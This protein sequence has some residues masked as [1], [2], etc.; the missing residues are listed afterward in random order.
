MYSTVLTAAA[1]FV[2]CLLLTPLARDAFLRWGIVDRPDGVR[3]L[4]VRPVPRAGGIPIAVSYALAYILLLLSPLKGGDYLGQFL[5]LVWALMPAAVLVFATG[6]L[7]DIWGLRPCEKLGGQLAAA[8]LACWGG[9]KIANVAGYAISGWLSLPL[10]VIW[11]AACTNAFNLID[12]V[13]GLAAGVGLVATL[14]IFLAALL[15]HNLALALATFP[16]AGCLLGF[17]R[18]NF[19]PASVFLGDSGSLLVG[20]L[21]GCYGV[22]WSQKSVTILGMTAPLMALALPLLDT[23]LAV[24]RRFLRGQ[25]IFGADRGHLHHRLLDRGLTPRRVVLLLYA[26]CG[27][28]AMP[29]LLQSTLYA[30]YTGWVLLLFLVAAVAGIQKLEYEEFEAARRLLF[31]GELRKLLNGQIALLDLERTISRTGTIEGCWSAIQ[32]GCREFGFARAELH[33]D[34]RIYGRPRP[35]TGA[36]SSWHVYVPLTDRDYVLLSRGAASA[37]RPGVVSPLAD[38]LRNRLPD[39]LAAL[40]GTADVLTGITSETQ[41]LLRLAQA[42]ESYNDSYEGEPVAHRAGP[43]RS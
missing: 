28:G 41:S 39:K 20:F 2:F 4:H 6:L 22:I 35:G 33:F 14:T 29:S 7:D 36:N 19:N 32:D 21:L 30:R 24:L 31:G 27:L 42:I 25:P 13:D 43:A 15:H 40:S 3:K 34:G 37:V 5:P 26:A 12:G 18:Y 8:L 10:T 17:L 11:L 38:L 16:L 9:V 1:A 23:G